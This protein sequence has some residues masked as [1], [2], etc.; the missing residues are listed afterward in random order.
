MVLKHHER[1]VAPTPVGWFNGVALNSKQKQRRVAAA[2]LIRRNAVASL[3]RGLVDAGP[4]LLITRE[5]MHG[6]L[7][8]PLIIAILNH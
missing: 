8:P 3:V 6:R 4:P 2:L 7:G 5:F 1:R